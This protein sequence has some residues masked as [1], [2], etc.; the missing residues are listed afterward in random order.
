MCWII[1]SAESTIRRLRSVSIVGDA[2]LFSDAT[3]PM[4]LAP[5]VRQI[6]CFQ[7]VKGG[8]CKLAKPNE[9]LL[10]PGH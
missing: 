1:A 8:R 6:D 10:R 2:R 5:V 7:R 4:E 9:V 3:G